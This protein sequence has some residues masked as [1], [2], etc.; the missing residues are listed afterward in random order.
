MTQIPENT[1]ARQEQQALSEQ[2]QIRR[3]KLEALKQA[4]QDPYAVTKFDVTHLSSQILADAQ[5]LMEQRVSVAGRM[6]ARRV[7][8]ARKPISSLNPT[9]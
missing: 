9:T 3:D 5:A 8:W 6:I 4:G 1:E 2:A 7:T